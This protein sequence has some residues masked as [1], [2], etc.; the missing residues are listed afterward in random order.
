[1]EP[2]RK[3]ICK[4]ESEQHVAKFQLAAIIF[5]GGGVIL[6]D[7][8]RLPLPVAPT[9]VNLAHSADYRHTWH[10]H[11]GKWHTTAVRQNNKSL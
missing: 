10:S 9:N 3:N 11:G 1:M 4:L 5:F 8:I 7:K 6:S 2:Q